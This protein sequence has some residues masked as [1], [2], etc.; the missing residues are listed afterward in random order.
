[1][2]TASDECTQCSLGQYCGTTQLTA[3]TGDCDPGYYCKRGNSDPNPDGSAPG[4]G[5][6]CPVSHY[7]PAGTSDPIACPAGTYNNVTH[8]S[9]CEPCHEGFFC[10]ENT[11]TYE[12]RGK[13]E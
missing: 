8:Q 6:P 1:M 12:V 7:C 2:L 9:V 10:P 3:P 11:T 13:N 4:T 5:G